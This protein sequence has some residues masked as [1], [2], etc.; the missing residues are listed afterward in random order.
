[1]KRD[2]L[3]NILYDKLC[4]KFGVTHSGDHFYIQFKVKGQLASAHLVLADIDVQVPEPVCPPGEEK[5]AKARREKVRMAR[6]TD[7][8]AS[9]YGDE[10]WLCPTSPTGYCWYD[11]DNDPLNYNCLGCGFPEERK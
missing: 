2:E 11:S 3:V 5:A 1:M 9:P 10:G 8:W 7:D 6:V 4:D